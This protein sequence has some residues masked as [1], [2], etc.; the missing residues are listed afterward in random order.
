MIYR[1]LADIVVVI[2]L[3]FILFVLFGGLLG[4]W[5]ARLLW[6][7]LPAFAWG[8]IVEFA[9]LICPLTPLENRLRYLGG[10]QG[11]SGGFI[12]HYLEP[13][14]YPPG[15]TPGIQ[16]VLGIFILLVNIAAYSTVWRLRSS[17]AL[18]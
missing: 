13:M 10:E 1:L 2:H 15:L 3:L 14:I 7:H 4:L 12:E 18:Q 16:V 5:R 8:L 17:K 9:G 11:Y 6:L